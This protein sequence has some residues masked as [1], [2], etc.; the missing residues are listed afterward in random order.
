MVPS[1]HLDQRDSGVA[2][3]TPEQDSQA[4]HARSHVL[5][6]EASVNP[7]DGALLL[8]SGAIEAGDGTVCLE[9]GT[10]PGREFEL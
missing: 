3:W 4:Q 7:E 1:A 5:S 10:S 6:W 2:Q 8:H 9:G